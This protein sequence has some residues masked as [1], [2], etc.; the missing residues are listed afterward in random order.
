MNKS[1]VCIL[2]TSPETV[3]EDYERLLRLA[4]YNKFLPKEN[5]LIIKLN[6]SWTKFFP[7]SSTPPWQLEGL[8][9][10]LFKDGYSKDKIFAVE[11]KT[12]VTNPVQGAKENKWMSVLQK[13]G[14]DFVP[15]TEVKWTKYEFKSKLLIL[16]R[17]FPEGIFIPEMF[18]KKNVIHLPTMKT[19]GHSITTG[20]VKNAFGGL[21]KETRHYGHKYIHETLVDL[22]L[23]QKELHPKVFALMDGTVCGDGAG[24]RTMIPR[25]KNYILASSDSVAIDAVAAKM[26]GF[27]PFEIP[28]LKM[29]HEYGLGCADLKE[30]EIIGEDIS[31]VNF[32]FKV[33][34][35]FVIWGDQMLRKGLLRPFEKIALHSPLV[36][37]SWIASGIYHDYFWL[38]L[39]GRRRIKKFMRTGWGRLFA[40]Y[41]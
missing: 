34:R 3:L 28:Y 7:A 16:N 39:I 13:Y 31:E 18:I 38:P 27:E 15:L 37:W 11:N 1:K 40:E 23:M 20:A 30:I 33:K 21:L 8:L 22:L 41:N 35:S 19:H 32:G 9:R 25:I 29:A 14:L 5:G 26:M 10:T 24:P 2:K 36:P 17:L 6:L 12:V 4:E